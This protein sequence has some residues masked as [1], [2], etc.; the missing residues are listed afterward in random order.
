[1]ESFFFVVVGGIV[2]WLSTGLA[3]WTLGMI[4]LCIHSIG[5]LFTRP[6]LAKIGLPMHLLFLVI[7]GLLCWGDFILIRWLA[8]NWP[9]AKIAMMVAA[10]FPGIFLLGIPAGMLRDARQV[11]DKFPS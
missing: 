11:V 10:V 8:T 3:M 6:E 9:T 2:G 7:A 1:M 5:L 4:G